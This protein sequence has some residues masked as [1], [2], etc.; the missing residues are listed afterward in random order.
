MSK[1]VM[2][3]LYQNNDLIQYKKGLNIMDLFSTYP[4]K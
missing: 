1:K 2:D 3:L 4:I